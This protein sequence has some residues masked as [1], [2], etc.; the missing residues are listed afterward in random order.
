M[1]SANSFKRSEAMVRKRKID[2]SITLSLRYPQD[3]GFEN[4]NPAHTLRIMS[5]VAERFELV[6][7][8]VFYSSFG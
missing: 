6:N 7:R 8:H 3:H 4:L 2:F 5:I 1:D